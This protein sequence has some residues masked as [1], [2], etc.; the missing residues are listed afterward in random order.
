MVILV[1]VVV[2]VKTMMMVLYDGN[3]E[4]LIVSEGN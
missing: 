2:V 3:G 1:M 4:V